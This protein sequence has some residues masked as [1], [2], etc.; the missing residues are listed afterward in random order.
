MPKGTRFLAVGKSHMG[1]ASSRGPTS[2]K[3]EVANGPGARGCPPWLPGDH[4]NSGDLPPAPC[5][6][7]NEQ[8]HLSAK[9]GLQP[10]C[11][12]GKGN[13]FN[14]LSYFSSLALSETHRPKVSLGT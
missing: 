7:A 14:P 2:R 3:P 9:I 11:L 1:R 13:S 6:E 10:R 4:A 5:P 8:S 12:G